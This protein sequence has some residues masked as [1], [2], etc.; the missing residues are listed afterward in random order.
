MERSTI[1]FD[2]VCNLCNFVIY[3]II[4]RDPKGRYQYASLQSDAGKKLVQPFGLPVT[5]T[6]WSIILVESG[7]CYIKSAAILRI[8]R[9][10]TF[11]WPLLSLFVVLPR[12]IRDFLYV[13][14]A[15][16]RYRWF[17]R[18]DACPLP[19][20]EWRDRFID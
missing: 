15:N 2:G 16:H 4:Q 6:P 18:M 19:R 11:P 8:C 1:L 20:P 10:L 5:D 3:F 13:F 14:V 12:F 7:R 9:H 17:G